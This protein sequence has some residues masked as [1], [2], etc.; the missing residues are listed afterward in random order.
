MAI[1]VSFAGCSTTSHIE[2]AKGVD[3]SK[4]K[5]FGWLNDSGVQAANRADNDII[6]NNI[7]NSISVELQKKNWMEADRQPDVWLDY[8][9]MV[10]KGV[11]RETD[12]AYIYPYTGYYY[13]SWRNRMGYFYNPAFFS[14]YRSYNVPFK[15]GTLTVNMVDAKTNKL[16]WQGW[17]KGDITDKGV[18]SKEAE[19]DVRSIFRKLDL[20]VE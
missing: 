11:R 5:T 4:Y 9:V 13:N 8:N 7:K 20:P 10:E 12:P 3:F 1:I 14:G 18:T 2:V 17:A 6:D 15:E 16:I 19:A